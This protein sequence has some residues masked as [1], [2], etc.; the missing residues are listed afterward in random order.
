MGKRANLSPQVYKWVCLMLAYV[1]FR[2]EAFGHMDLLG[3]VKSAC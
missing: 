3:I 2:R 1:E